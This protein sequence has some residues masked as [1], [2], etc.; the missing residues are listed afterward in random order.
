MQ[1]PIARRKKELEKR[2]NIHHKGKDAQNAY[3]GGQVQEGPR[4][5]AMKIGERKP[6]E[7]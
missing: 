4:L 3:V 5:D 7:S 2:D 6:S 1:A